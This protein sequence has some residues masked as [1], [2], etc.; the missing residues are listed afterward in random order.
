LS[1]SAIGIP[2]PKSDKPGY[3]LSESQQR[4]KEA[5]EW[6]I[7][8]DPKRPGKSRIQLYKEKQ[9]DYTRAL[10][11][12]I[13]DFA[14]ALELIKQDPKNATVEQQAEAYDQWLQTHRLAYDN[15]AEAAY[16]EWVTIGQK[17]DV[18]HYF[19]IVD[20]KSAMAR[21]ENSKVC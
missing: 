15:L 19:S 4:Y 1:G 8:E 6:L 11:R 3:E 13:T 10:Q 5:M 20:T 2:V 7:S 9:D 21:V 16:M 14:Q 18:E 17:S 12:R